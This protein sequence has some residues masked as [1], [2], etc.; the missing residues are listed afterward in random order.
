MAPPTLLH[1][2]GARRGFHGAAFMRTKSKLRVDV[3]RKPLWGKCRIQFNIVAY[4]VQNF[5]IIMRELGK[6][7]MGG[8]FNSSKKC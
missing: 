2:T 4:L 1:C 6:E 8:K 5:N 3:S 7:K